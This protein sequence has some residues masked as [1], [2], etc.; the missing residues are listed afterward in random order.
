M[1]RTYSNDDINFNGDNEIPKTSNI[2][3][4]TPSAPDFGETTHPLDLVMT[5]PILLS[6]VHATIREEKY[7][8]ELGICFK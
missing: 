4:T 2:N 7:M 5:F 6:K 8:Q 3:M 1:K